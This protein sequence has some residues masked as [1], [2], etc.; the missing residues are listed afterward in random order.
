MQ[1]AIVFAR[2]AMIM[3]AD[4]LAP[5]RESIAAAANPP[6]NGFREARAQAIEA[7]ERRYLIDTLKQYNGNITQSARY[8]LQDRRAFG[9]LVKRHGI[10]RSSY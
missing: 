10:D 8:A 2:G 7:F 4:I 9:R 5:E 3:P 1:R 6:A